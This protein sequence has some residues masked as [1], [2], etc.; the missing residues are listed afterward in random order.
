MRKKPTSWWRNIGKGRLFLIAFVTLCV[1]AIFRRARGVRGTSDPHL[2]GS[3]WRQRFPHAFR[4]VDTSISTS[5]APADSRGELACRR[6]L[7]ER[8]NRPFPKQRP[9]FLRNPVTKVD[10]ELDCY[11]AQ[12]ALAV[13]YQ[14]KQHYHY[15]PHFHSSRD[16]FLN[17]KYRDQIKRDLCLKNNIVLIEVPYTVI[18]IESFLDLKLKEHGYI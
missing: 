16:A 4:P 12:L 6:H 2:L 11:N 9:T 1:Y 18:D 15:V 13:E 3:D 8:F 17:Q 10:L 14:G 5:T 7:E